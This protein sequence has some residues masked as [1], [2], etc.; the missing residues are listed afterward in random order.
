MIRIKKGLDIP[1]SGKPVQTIS[2][3]A[4]VR[5]VA[6]VAEDYVGLRPAM[7]VAEGDRVRLGQVLLTDKRH[8][9]IRFTA[10]GSGVVRGVHRAEKRRLVSV[11]IELDGDD[12]ETFP[13][14]DTTTVGGAEV[15][16]ILTQ[17]GLWTAL[18]TRP[19]NRVPD[20]ESEPHS[21]FVT[22]MDTN[23]LA[24][25]P[26]VIL[27][28]RG[29]DFVLGLR[30]L[31]R[32]TPGTVHVCHAAERAV[33][34]GEVP[35]VSLHAFAGPHPA[36][37]PGTHIH[38][39][40]PVG[41]QRTAWFI[42]Y[43][44]VI[45]YGALFRTGQ[46][47]TSRVIALGG[48]SVR[49]PRLLRTR[50]GACLDELVDGELLDGENR[51]VSGSLLSGRRSVPPANYLGRYHVQVSVLPEGRHR[52]LLGWQMPGRDK[53]S[54]TRAFAAAWLQ[55]PAAQLAWNTSTHGSR[56]A[57]VPIGVYEKV[58]PLDLL[59]T[60]LLRALVV[61]DTDQAQALGCLELDEDDLGLCTF[62][63]PSKY[64]YGAILRQNLTTI[65]RE[66]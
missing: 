5:H 61:G 29:D 12:Q 63:C 65:E 64:D 38:F 19:Y 30:I 51:V 28:E 1:V 59:P 60:Q 20:P 9:E 37:L 26:G 62:V 43:Q 49:E 44:D 47:D 15:R 23:P 4:E 11:A 13:T 7:R 46:W 25:D 33:P 55:T 54:V 66:G 42:G 16:G 6:V 52:E 17:S 58:V 18:R 41:M 36:G 8:P 10:P 3:G 50:V 14:P 31:T 57:M 53:F 40:A 45:A 48:P 24:A 21:I 34:G 32:L 35:G 56:R 27:S 39:L 2:Y 22:A